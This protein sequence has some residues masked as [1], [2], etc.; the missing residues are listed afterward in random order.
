MRQ[1]DAGRIRDMRFGNAD[2][3]HEHATAVLAIGRLD[4]K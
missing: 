2:G 3:E 4:D 1:L